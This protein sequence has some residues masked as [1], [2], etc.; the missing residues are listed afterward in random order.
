MSIQPII[1]STAIRTLRELC[2]RDNDA[3]LR[4][5]LG[6]FMQDTPL[7]I[8][9]ME[10]SLKSND[11]TR[12]KR[13]AHSIKGS[14]ANIGAVELKEVAGRLESECAG[15]PISSLAPSVA[16]IRVAYERARAELDRIIAAGPG[17]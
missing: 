1:D 11:A 6:M 2:P 12:F 3:F 5:L 17:A 16:E 15:A 10:E 8:A 4:E 14:S 9:E 7:R 13:A